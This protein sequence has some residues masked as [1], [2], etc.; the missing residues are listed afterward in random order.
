MNLAIPVDLIELGC[1][2]FGLSSDD[3]DADMTAVKGGVVVAIATGTNPTTG[4]QQ[5][6]FI[7]ATPWQRRIRF[8][9]LLADHVRQADPPNTA[10][11]R[12]LIR[13]A[14]GVVAQSKRVGSDEARCIHLQHDLMEALAS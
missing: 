9:E 2:V 6:K 10:S 5:R 7:T 14:A 8:D 11:I 3:T 4:E 12:A 13:T 1:S